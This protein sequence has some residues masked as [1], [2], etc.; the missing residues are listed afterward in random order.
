MRARVGMDGPLASDS[1][2]EGTHASNSFSHARSSEGVA[3]GVAIASAGDG[4]LFASDRT[5]AIQRN[6]ADL[7]TG[8]FGSAARLSASGSSQ[9]SKG[10]RRAIERHGDLD[11]AGRS[12]QTSGAGVYLRRQTRIQV[13]SMAWYKALKR[14]GI[15]NKHQNVAVIVSPQIPR[16]QWTTNLSKLRNGRGTALR[17]HRLYWPQN[18]R[19]AALGHTVYSVCRMIAYMQSLRV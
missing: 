17:G 16:T 12:S 8:G 3:T 13:S 2:L 7:G 18:Q 19:S 5:S 1:A 10:D 6:W 9:R 14:A 11:R 4:G 15:E